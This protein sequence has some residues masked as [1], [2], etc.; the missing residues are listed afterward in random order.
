MKKIDVGRGLFAL[1]DDCDYLELSKYKWTAQRRKH[2][3]YAMRSEGGKP[4]LMHRQILDLKQRFEFCD[5]I[6]G[7]GLNNQRDNLRRCTIQENNLN[8]SG[9][10]N[11][12]SQLKG[13][14]R[15]NGKRS[16][17][18]WIS[19]ITWSGVLLYLGTFTTKEAAIK[20][21]NDKAKELHGDF[22][23]LHTL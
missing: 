14:S 16:G 17:E 6:D 8:K 19:R 13:I 11:S 23:K 9:Y 18:R 2:T 7:N 1:V 12:Q 4:V 5:H 21:Y 22:A 15:K 3:F 10:K 20:A